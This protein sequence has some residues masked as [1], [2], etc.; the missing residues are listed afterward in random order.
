MT[1]IELIAIERKEQIEK[2]GWDLTRDED[3]KSGELVQ[4]AIFCLNPTN[5]VLWPWHDNGIGTHFYHKI[6]G[7]T[8]QQRIVIAGAFCAAELDRLQY[9]NP[10]NTTT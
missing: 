1:G 7:K 8:D 3:Y 2:H 6:L 5:S 10:S 4:A 9:I